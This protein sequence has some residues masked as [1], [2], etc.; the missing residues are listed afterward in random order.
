[1]LS[2]ELIIA[3]L[4]EKG[5]LAL[6]LITI[7]EGPLI[8]ILGGFLVSMGIFKL[9]YT[10]PLILLA[11][12]IGDILAYTI[13]YLGRKRYAVKILGWLKI[14]E[15]KL[16]GLDNFFKRH[17]GKSIFLAKFITGAGSWT[18]I[19]AGMARVRLKRFL[20][21]S[22]SAGIL[23]TAAYMAAGYFFGNIYK[24]LIKW[25]NVTSAVIILII[26]IGFT[27]YFVK[28][29]FKEKYKSFSKTYK[30]IKSKK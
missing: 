6:F 10:Y 24:I 29:Y 3:E 26:L 20:K 1:M 28:N 18:L 25:M 15:D 23:K 11:D 17:G 7:I 13:G 27:F 4:I 30:K 9:Y 19:S 16:L 21:Y 2:S 5:Y 14:S 22:I 8:T 12:T